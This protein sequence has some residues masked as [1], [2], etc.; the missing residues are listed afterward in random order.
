VAT[1]RSVREQVGRLSLVEGE[2]HVLAAPGAT[3]IAVDLPSA[4][5]APP[6]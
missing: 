3:V 2:Y 4:S 5:A 6:E 1:S